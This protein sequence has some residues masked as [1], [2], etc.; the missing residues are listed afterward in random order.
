MKTLLVALVALGLTSSLLAQKPEAPRPVKAPRSPTYPVPAAQKSDPALEQ[1]LKDYQ[2][3]FNKGDAKALAA[4]Y[5]EN[6]I[7]LGANSEVLYGRA[8]VE[9]FY[10]GSFAGTPGALSVRPGRTEI[11]T[12]DV[13]VLEGAYEVAG[14][15]GLHGVYF[16]TVVRQNGQWRFASV[17]PVPHKQ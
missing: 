16:L 3:A 13:A 6:A 2:A 1:L 4:F 7:R 10:A 15:T 12:P 8:A 9:K 5:T 14:T 11:I 17:V